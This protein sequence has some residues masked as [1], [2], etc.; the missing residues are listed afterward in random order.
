MHSKSRHWVCQS[1]SY[2]VMLPFSH[3][4]C[5]HRT[6]YCAK[7]NYEFGISRVMKSL[8]PYSKK[9][10]ENINEPQRPRLRPS[11]PRC[12]TITQ[13]AGCVSA[14]TRPLKLHWGDRECGCFTPCTYNTDG[15]PYRVVHAWQPQVAL[16][17]ITHVCMWM[18]ILP[19]VL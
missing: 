5:T 13:C 9:V 3:T 11:R 14:N 7:G 8:E 2:T 17:F 12:R 16:V 4:T 1:S 15:W 19:Y 10:H 6:L 18:T